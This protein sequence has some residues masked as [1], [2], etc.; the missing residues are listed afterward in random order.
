LESPLQCVAGVTGANLKKRI[1]AIMVNRVALRLNF[2]K[3]FTLA[4][5]GMAA[6]AVPIGVGIM[7]A[8]SI[9][10]QAQPSAAQSAGAA[11]PKFARVSVTPCEAFRHDNRK[12]VPG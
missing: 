7:N 4:V 8:P 5:A 12:L 9:R 6:L 2:A 1:E 3:K 11:A 10:A